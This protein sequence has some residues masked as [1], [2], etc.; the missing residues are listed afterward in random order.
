VYEGDCIRILEGEHAGQHGTISLIDGDT[1][2]VTTEAGQPDILSRLD[3]EV[4]D[5][6]DEPRDYMDGD[7]SPL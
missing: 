3:V 2:H 7:F 4:I 5:C 6:E 1:V